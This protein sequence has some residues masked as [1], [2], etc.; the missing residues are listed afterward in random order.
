MS[1]NEKIQR[2]KELASFTDFFTESVINFN[3]TNTDYRVSFTDPIPVETEWLSSYDGQRFFELLTYNDIFDSITIKIPPT[4][5]SINNNDVIVNVNS[6]NQYYFVV[7]SAVTAF[8]ITIDTLSGVT[9]TNYFSA[10]DYSKCRLKV[11]GTPQITSSIFDL[12]V[13]QSTVLSTVTNN[14]FTFMYFNTGSLILGFTPTKRTLI[15]PTP[16]PTIT[17]TITPTPTLTPTPTPTPTMRVWIDSYTWNDSK[18]WP[19]L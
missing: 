10:D 13:T 1:V 12:Y 11:T 7:S 15:Q 16:S 18:T 5:I 8:H 9:F 4:R 17:P 19:E 14:T 6:V 2:L 3:K